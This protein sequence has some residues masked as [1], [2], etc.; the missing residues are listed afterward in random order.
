M[1]GDGGGEVEASESHGGGGGRVS[2]LVRCFNGSKFSVQISLDSTV[3]SFK[4]VIAEK[5]DVAAERLRLIYKG[6]IL[7]DDQTLES[8][9]NI[10]SRYACMSNYVSIC[11]FQ[12]IR[13]HPA[14]S[15]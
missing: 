4:S 11:N 9:G 10:Q 14:T 6:Q 12:C 5:C 1:A 3:E 15:Q 7:K 13:S 2:L 8:Y